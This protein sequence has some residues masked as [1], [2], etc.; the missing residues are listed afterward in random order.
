MWGY[1]RDTQM[2]PAKPPHYQ[3]AI[4]GFPFRVLMLNSHLDNS[5]LPHFGKR[6][7]QWL[8]EQ[9]EASDQPTLIAIHHP[10][11]QTGIGFI[12]MVGRGW[13]RGLG[14]V[15][16]RHPQVL[17]IICGHGHSDLHGRLSK[18]P[19]QMVGSTA[20][21]LIADRVVDIAPAF[22]N[23]RVPPMLH[24]WLD[25][26]IVS[27]YYPWPVGVDAERIDKSSNMHWDDLKDHMR[28]AMK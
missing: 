13:Y 3:Y 11:F 19:V 17:K 22:D 21:Q 5:E 10:P 16:A 12:D 1:F 4:E 9:L 15:V 28:G 8:Q 7:L 18:V 2:F 27:G 26:D 25:G 24:H 6:R 20:H 14:E 23:A